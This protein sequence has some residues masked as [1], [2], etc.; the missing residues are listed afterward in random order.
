MKKGETGGACGTNGLNDKCVH[1]FSRETDVPI[2]LY[3][4]PFFLDVWDVLY[5]IIIIIIIIIIMLWNGEKLLV[6]SE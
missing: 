4:T 5:A 2:T 6:L 1:N 3:E